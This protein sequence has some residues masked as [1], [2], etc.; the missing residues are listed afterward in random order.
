M[1]E[2]AEASTVHFGRW[3]MVLFILGVLGPFVLYA[4]LMVANA[5]TNQAMDQGDA[6]LMAVGFGV[7]AQLLA[8]VL[9]IVGC[10]T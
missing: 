5:I 7:L 10:G 3:S 4:L 2:T 6:A 1:S 9:G 8:F